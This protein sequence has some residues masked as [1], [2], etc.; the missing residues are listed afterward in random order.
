VGRGGLQGHVI[1]IGPSL[2]ID[3]SEM[4]DGIKRLAAAC[5]AVS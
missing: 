1:R 3:E 4:A 2:L 5:R